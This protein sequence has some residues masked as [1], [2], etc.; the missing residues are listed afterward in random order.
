MQIQTFTFNPFQEN[1][2]VLFD[3][4][5]EAIIIDPGC[6]NNEENKVLQ[7]FITSNNLNP[8]KLVNTHC[9]IDHVFGWDF[10]FKTWGL[11]PFY[12]PKDKVLLPRIGDQ[13]KMFG[14]DLEPIAEDYGF[15]ITEKE[16]VHFGNS[17]LEIFHCPG[18][19]P[20]H[21]V[22]FH[23]DSNQC[24]VG[25][26]IFRLGVGRTDLPF[27]NPQDLE[28]SIREVIYKLPDDCVLFSGHGSTTTVGY[29]KKSNPF[30]RSI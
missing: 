15:E 29:E 9:H 20:G 27:C 28:Q 4:T 23:K 11:K 24:L 10:V 18:H 1:T 3:E 30:V 8:V 26:V 19:A 13:A 14:F 21:I 2:Y 12:H 22:L 5:K 6:S 7:D 17:V 16:Q 25:D